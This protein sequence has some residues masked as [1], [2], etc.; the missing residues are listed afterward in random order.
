MSSFAYLMWETIKKKN[1]NNDVDRLSAEVGRF[2]VMRSWFMIKIGG[3]DL[4]FFAEKIEE[5]EIKDGRGG[6][7]TRS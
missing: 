2:V 1:Q 6:L 4:L 7:L 3:R 5:E